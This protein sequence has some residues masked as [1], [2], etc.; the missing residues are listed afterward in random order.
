MIYWLHRLGVPVS[1]IIPLWVSYGLCTLLAPVVFWV[2]REKR[3]T[4]IR[5]FMVVLGHGADPREA[6]RMA[7]S[8]FINYRK[9]CVDMLRLTGLHIYDLERRVTVNGWEHFVEARDQGRGL[10]VVG[11][12]IGNS[13]LAAALLARRGFPV[14]VI[15]EPLQPPRWDA[16][17]QAARTA[18]GLR[19]IPLGSNAIRLL[20]LL[21]EKGILAVLVDRPVQGQGISVNF[22][23][24]TVNVPAGAAA[25]ALK[26]DAQ[27]LAAYI[28]RQGNAY[29]ANISPAIPLPVTG[30]TA[31]DLQTVTQAIF[32]HLERVIKQYPDQWFMFRPMWPT[33]IDT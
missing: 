2:W 26:S 21:R 22:F 18:V 27:I 31:L 19:V 14:H 30:D 10:I 28:V 1:R 15:A 8:A 33:E 23:G 11:A 9:Y 13:D 16:L 3:V 29:V 6:R 12:H 17:V 32:D 20:R 25:L 7:R 24:H 5:N 4:T